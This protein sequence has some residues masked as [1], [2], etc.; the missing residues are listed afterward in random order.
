MIMN[1]FFEK[2]LEEI[3]FDRRNTIHE[4]GLDIFYKNAERQVYLD[5]KK[6]DILTWE[7][8]NDVIYARIIEFKREKVGEA[9][10]FQGLHYYSDF[11]CATMG[12]FKDYHVEVILIGTE[13][14]ANVRTAMYVSNVIKAYEYSYGFDG[15]YFK[16]AGNCPLSI[17]ELFLTTPADPDGIA[18]SNKLKGV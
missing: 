12:S 3:V 13:I 10:L 11:I 14:S 9:A 17:R 6:I 2:T 15:V 8:A 7:I 16:E 5:G 1:D 18:F 4:R